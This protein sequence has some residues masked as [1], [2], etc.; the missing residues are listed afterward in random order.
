[1][2]EF[3]SVS[4]LSAFLLKILRGPLKPN[5]EVYNLFP[6]NFSPPKT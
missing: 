2:D 5:L 4:F 1:M 3:I 6:L